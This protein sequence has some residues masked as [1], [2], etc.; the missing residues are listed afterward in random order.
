MG[1]AEEV[2]GGDRKDPK[3]V[4]QWDTVKL[5]LPGSKDYDPNRPFVRKV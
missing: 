3:N 1:V 5:N 4:F 2:I